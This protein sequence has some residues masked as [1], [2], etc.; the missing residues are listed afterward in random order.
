MRV[1]RDTSLEHS[2]DVLRKT[3]IASST[4]FVADDRQAGRDGGIGPAGGDDDSGRGNR[5]Q[6]SRGVAQ[7]GAPA[8]AIGS[9]RRTDDRAASIDEVPLFN[10]EIE[11]RAMPPAVQDLRAR[12]AARTRS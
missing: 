9:L 2:G 1:W 12:V 7:P 8:A 6:S 3:P 5:G 4:A 10:E 11:V